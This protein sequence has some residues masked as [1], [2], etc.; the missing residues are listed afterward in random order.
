MKVTCF[1]K[2]I[3]ILVRQ[4]QIVITGSSEPETKETSK[5][6]ISMY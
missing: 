3:K 2:K 5:K 1:I 6:S 4:L